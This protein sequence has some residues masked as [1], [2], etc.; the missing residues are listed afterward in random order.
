MD[1][2]AK[3]AALGHEHCPHG[4]AIIAGYQTHGRGSK[5]RSWNSNPDDNL[6]CAIVLRYT[7]GGIPQ[8]IT[9]KTGLAVL[10]TLE[11]T[12][13][14]LNQRLQIKWP[15]D[16]YIIDDKCGG[17]LGGGKI[18]GILTEATITAD[19]ATVIVGIGINLWQSSFPDSLPLASSLA[20][21]GILPENAGP[22]EKTQTIQALTQNI[23]SYLLNINDLK[24]EAINKRLFM[25]GKTISFQTPQGLVQGRLDGVAANGEIII[26]GKAY[27][28]GEILL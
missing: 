20:L 26:A 6:M 12:F 15:N 21:N 7:P 3:Q 25:Q 2:A 9:L 19:A 17:G 27:I 13:P 28:S 18:S 10:Q 16:V 22:D 23:Q 8:A 11:A 14:S 24:P 4:T 5:G 1:E